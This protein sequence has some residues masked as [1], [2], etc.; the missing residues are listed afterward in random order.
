[1][2]GLT[3]IASAIAEP[4]SAVKRRTSTAP[5]A[6]GSARRMPAFSIEWAAGFLDGEGCIH[7]A[8]QTYRSKRRDTLRLRVY[9][10]QAHLEVLEHFRDGVGIDAR[11]YKVKRTAQHNKQV[12]TLN[13]EGKKA[14]ALIALLMPHLIRK[15]EEAQAAM[16][17]WVEGRVGT[18]WGPKGVPTDIAALRQRLYLKLRSLK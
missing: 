16:T 1:M 5:N 8:R 6:F 13:F 17:F 10:V 12:Y 11:I 18:R 9:I 14:M 15:Q 4:T 2:N 3:H 7:I